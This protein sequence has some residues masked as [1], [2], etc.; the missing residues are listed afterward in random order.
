MHKKEMPDEIEYAVAEGELEFSNQ[1]LT[2]GLWY[3]IIS[4]SIHNQDRIQMKWYVCM[5]GGGVLRFIEFR[6]QNP[7]GNSAL[8]SKLRS[9]SGVPDRMKSCPRFIL[10]C[11]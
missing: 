1:T 8:V 2:S 7:A 6:L 4:A 10:T 5:G 11:C 3:F 9:L